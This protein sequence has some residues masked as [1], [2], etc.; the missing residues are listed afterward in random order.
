MTPVLMGRWQTRLFVMTVFGI[1][2]TLPFA[3]VGLLQSG[4]GALGPFVALVAVTVIGLTL[5]GFYDGMQRK[6]WDHDWPTWLQVAAGAVEGVFA[7]GVLC[8]CCVLWPVTAGAI[9]L[10]PLHYGLVW[11]AGFLFVQGPVYVV[12]PQWRYRGGRIV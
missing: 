1:P 8:G 5:D 9:V 3:V 6:R 11:L 4:F 2:L 7:W 12:F 10:F